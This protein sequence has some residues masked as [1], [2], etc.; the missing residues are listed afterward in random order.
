MVIDKI[1][2]HI[3]CIMENHIITL[4]HINP[5]H[6]RRKKKREE[7]MKRRG[8]RKQRKEEERKKASTHH[9]VPWLDAEHKS[10]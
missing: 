4:I 1:T 10:G 9:H 3:T 2:E 6:E 7:T 5:K 8:G